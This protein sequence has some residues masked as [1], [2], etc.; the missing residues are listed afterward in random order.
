[1]S[2]RIAVT[3]G[4]GLLGALVVERLATQGA[5]ARVISRR[6][7]PAGSRDWAVAD[8]R[9]GQG[10][11]DALAGADVVVHCA[12]GFGRQAETQLA[13][14]VVDAARRTGR[15]HLVYISIVGVDRVPLGYYQ[16]KL[17]A[18][19]L[20]ERSGLPYT[21]LRAT[22]FHDMLR[23]I[24]ARL[25]RLPVMPVPDIRLQP[26]DSGEVADRLA[27]ITTGEP[28][29]RVP[30]IGGPRVQHAGELA[31]IFLRATAR[32]RPVLPIRLPGNTFRAYRADGHLAA[33]DAVGTITFEDHL[34]AHHAPLGTA[35]RDRP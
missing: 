24:F 4:T 2:S 22:Q 30:D 18:E 3:G 8:L 25:V 17:A 35:Y 5:E 23:A 21:I 33:E 12:T 19:Q 14:T 15:P 11:R 26:I 29:G 20:I 10:V 13:R 6:P 32:Q 27:D 9:T 1:M 7:R 16:G 34:A 31:R 28:A